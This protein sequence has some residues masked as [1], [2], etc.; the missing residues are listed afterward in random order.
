MT[1]SL[2]GTEIA[3]IDPGILNA[4]SLTSQFKTGTEVHL[5]HSGEDAITQITQIL[6]NRSSISAIRIVSH[7]SN[8]ALQLSGEAI[9]DLASYDDQLQ[10]WSQSLTPDADIL[11]Y[12]CNV[13][14][15]A[16]GKAFVNQLSQLTGAD[17]AASDDLTGNAAL[18][19]D[20][21]LE[22]QTGAIEAIAYSDESYEGTL[23]NFTVNTL[24]DVVNPSDNLLSLREAIAAANTQAGTDNI[25][26]SVNSTITLSGSELEINGN[27]NIYGNGASVLTISGNNASRVFNIN[28][29]TV[30]LSNLTIAQGNEGG[31]FNN[32]NVTLQACTLSNNL[33]SFGGAA[34]VN[35]TDANILT[36]TGSTFTNNSSSGNGAVI[37]N[38]GTVTMTGST[39]TGNSADS[40]GVIFNNGTVTL[41]NSIFRNNSSGGSG[42]VLFNSSTGT[43]TVTGSTFTGNSSG[44]S[45]GVIFNTNRLE[46][47]GSTFTGNSANNNL[48]GGISNGG[49]LTMTGSTFTN[50][51]ARLGGGL[52]NGN[53][54][55]AIVNSCTFIGNQASGNGGAIYDTGVLSLLNSTLQN[56][57]AG[58]DGGG[59]YFGSSNAKVSGSTFLSN[60]ATNGGAIAVDVFV[61][62]T[63]LITDSVLRLNTA[64]SSGGGIFNGAGNQVMLR[65]SNIRFNTAPTGTDLFGD[66]ISGGFNVIGKGGGFTGIVNLVNG[67]V[68]VVS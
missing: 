62:S 11:L 53:G 49:T 64:T 55:E 36:V 54:T 20:W 67:D 18:G 51:S 61:S 13:A 41:T 10:L 46:V 24:N 65:R 39:F 38:N 45:G 14:A 35:N 28:S 66:Y 12:G 50:N 68:I 57:R 21:D 22:Y 43:V 47:T 7:G 9:A 58:G 48:G 32:G 33:A 29:G 8:G 63:L 15:D 4:D 26:F 5:L 31:I 30:T 6:A 37:F 59:I 1:T 25:F 17:I 40:G 3:F 27:L 42:G 16:A 56:N 60:S 19:G 23:A 44:G 2:A 34:I 52:S